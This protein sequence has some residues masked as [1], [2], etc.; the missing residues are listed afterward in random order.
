MTPDQSA[1]RQNMF[2][3]I[4]QFDVEGIHRCMDDGLDPM[5]VNAYGR[6]LL[7]ALHFAPGP[8]ALDRDPSDFMV[9]LA[10]VE[11]RLLRAGAPVKD[12]W[13]TRDTLL[14]TD[15]LTRCF[16]TVLEDH[17]TAQQAAQ[18]L[19]AWLD[20]HIDL[21]PTIVWGPPLLRGWIEAMQDLGDGLDPPILAF[22]QKSL[23]LMLQRGVTAAMTQNISAGLPGYQA[24]MEPLITAHARAERGGTIEALDEAP[25]RARPRP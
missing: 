1:L 14:L 6:S 4:V 7:L 25:S 9:A 18:R 24:L 3:A 12:Q 20:P 22:G 11:A 17:A 19:G 8:E 2:K 23:A 5:A 13:V 21:G 10:S 15:T 16:Y